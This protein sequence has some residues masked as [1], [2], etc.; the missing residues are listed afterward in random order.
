ML[1]ATTLLMLFTVVFFTA[2]AQKNSDKILLMTG[3][4]LEGLVTSSDSANLYYTFVKKN[5]KEKSQRLDLERVFSVINAQGEEE[6]YYVMDTLV[7]DYFSEEEMRDYIAGERDAA[8]YSRSNWTLLAGIPITAAAGY[9]LSSSILV[10]PV[11]FVYTVVGALPPYKIKVEKGAKS[12]KAGN[13]AYVLG[14]E[15]EARTKRVFKSM[16][17]GLVGTAAGFAFGV[18]QQE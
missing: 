18:S 5:G 15:R 4:T 1:K 10:F 7:G 9:A 6:V 16:I 13:P 2:Q 12:K 17:A 14:Y 3:K 8:A 11:P